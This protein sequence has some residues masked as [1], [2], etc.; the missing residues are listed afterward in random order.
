MT[1]IT[2]DGNTAVA[3]IAYKLSEVVPIYPITPSTPMAE[4]CSAASNKK[5]K[6]IFNEDVKTIEMQSEAGVA[7]VLHGALLS[8][9]L[10]CTFTCSQG[11]LLMIPNMY[12]I[13]GE[14]LPAVIHASA[15]SVSAHALSIFGDHSDV[16]ATRQ[17]GFA[18]LT[19]S[20]VQ[21][22]HDMALI[23]HV[24][25]NKYNMPILHFFDG[26]RTS[27]EYQKIEEIPNS[28]ITKMFPDLNKIDIKI[29]ALSPNSPKM[30]GSA[31][32]PDVF[33]QN[34]ELSSKKY[35]EFSKNLLSEFETFKTLT[36][37]DY[38]PYEFIGKENAKY[39]IIS[40][41]SSTQTI[42]ETLQNLDCDTALLRV[43]LF[44]PFD[45]NMLLD[46]IPKTIEKICVLDKT[47]EFGSENPLYLDVCSAILKSGRKTKVI[48]GRY[49]LGGKEFSPACVKAIIENLE[50]TNSKDNFTVGINDDVL[51]SSLK[52]NNYE[53]NL[54]QKQIKIFG[55]GS[56][57]S[58][59][60]SKSIIRILG[61]NT[62]KY[63]QGFFEYDSKKAGS[64]TISHLRLCNDKI[65]SAYLVKSPDI[66][67]INNFSFVHRYNCL[68][69][70]KNGG[71]VIFNTVFNK[72]ELDKI[73]PNNYIKT[74]KEKKAK[75]FII[76][77]QKI[78]KENGLNEKI[79]IIMESAL[80]KSSKIIS[81]D[82]AKS[83]MTKEI[84]NLFSK[85][86][87]AVVEKNLN[88]M[89]E[90]FS[91]TVE[92]SVND[93][94]ENKIEQTKKVFPNEIMTKIQSLKGNDLPVSAF[95]ANGSLE[96]DSA[97]FEKR[98]IALN[99][100]IWLPE[101]CIQCGHCVMSC[102]HGALKA[103]LIDEKDDPKQKDM[104]F[105][106]A[107]GLKGH[108]YRI[109][110]S[111]EDCTGCGVCFKTCPSLKKAIEMAIASKTLDIQK[112]NFEISEGLKTK[113]AFNQNFPKGLQFKKSYFHFPG[114]CAGCG[115]TPYIR[116]ASTLFGER[117]MIANATGCSSIY[118]GSY[119]SCPFAKDEN[120]HG[121]AW[122][123]SL[124]EDNAEFGLGIRLGSN[125]ANNGDKSV[126]IIGGDGWAVDIG[127]GGL[128]HVLQSKE[129]V[130]IL[131]LDNET[132]SNTGGQ[133]SKSTPLGAHVKFA[134][135][136]KQTKKKNL[137]LLAM[138]YQNAYVAQVS[139]GADM[140]QC[141]KAFKEAESF[142]GPSLIIA[143]SPCVEHG[144]DMSTTMQEMKNAVT[145][146]YFN[147]YRYNPSSGLTLD[148]DPE[149]KTDDF[150]K[151]ERR[152]NAKNNED[153]ELL[154][155]NNEACKKKLK[156]LKMLEE[157]K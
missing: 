20:S 26:F 116:L 62:D 98:G 131:V 138:S 114:A 14:G 94:Q 108:K 102:P 118:C 22:C 33:F 36:G 71:I 111:P 76:N 84:S 95:N 126:W 5:E 87:S 24:C 43:R 143:Y 40:M 16:M 89:N 121:P 110:L 9:A 49:G 61:N 136:G 152:F 113:E 4:F 109:Q 150:T 96:T 34:K 31:Q 56:D 88:A 91:S 122:A 58:V 54:N 73:L 42:E 37:R 30:Y 15:R 21:E 69:G 124:F 132:Y 67:C 129:N 68:D 154:N 2:V 53:N 141:I 35:L 48:S 155:Q 90:G 86:G 47:K 10:S 51:N 139:L 140:N 133:A 79:N 19:S 52:L 106:D 137:G 59:S 93:L 44:R 1:K 6:N 127:F 130:N 151:N 29:N 45:E 135:N 105:A 125:Y 85:K 28:V 156:I 27:H 32:N 134:E 72:D 13:A 149:V 115:E 120:G 18:M 75:V 146:G 97:K 128:D 123:N 11:L 81:E 147:L 8:G 148:Y 74:L 145:S 99:L 7:G 80:F 103:I 107:I 3:K 12:K 82:V 117:M 55:L 77:A 23:A 38:K 153:I 119:P 64:L 66:I 57:G 104:P 78:A 39:L 100:P 50:S 144:F 63:V 65:Q 70:L 46:S 41:A 157:N 25:A 17:T 60:A 83:E 112:K 101:N 142:N 92:V